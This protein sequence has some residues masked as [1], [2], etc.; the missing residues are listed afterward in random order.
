MR[1]RLVGV[2]LALVLPCAAGAQLQVE[3][4]EIDGAYGLIAIPAGW[5]GSLFIYAHG[6]TA[7]ERFLAPLPDDVTLANFTQKLPLLLQ[8]SMIPALSG[9]AVAT[10]TFSSV[11]WYVEDAVRDVER[12]RRHFVRRHGRPKH[13]YVWGHS[14]GGMVTATVIEKFPTVYDG[15]LPMCGPV[16]GARR[17]FNGAFDLRVL[18]EWVC[19]DVPGSAF[20]CGLCSDGRTRCLDDAHCPAHQACGGRETPAPPELGLGA[21]AAPILE[22]FLQANPDHYAKDLIREEMERMR[23]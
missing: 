7:D 21:E 2:L 4:V 19:R 17:N 3:T 11:G 22:R 15:A 12:L 23:R 8:A 5:N 18:Y 1:T 16:A 20:A 13:T 6:Y 14:G 10:T 9:Y